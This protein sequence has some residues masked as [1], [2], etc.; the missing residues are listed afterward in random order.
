MRSLLIAAS[1]L[2]A[3]GVASSAGAQTWAGPRGVNVAD[4]HRYET[5]RLRQRSQE[6]AGFARQNQLSAR[7]TQRELEAARRPEPYL[8]LEPT[9][10]QTPEAAGRNREATVSGV[11]R[12]DDWLARTPR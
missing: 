6:Q 9:L 1:V 5:E 3:M 4:Q 11:T 8:R 10:P 7:L 2:V 12:I